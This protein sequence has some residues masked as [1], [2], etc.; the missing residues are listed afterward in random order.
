LEDL[1]HV[2]G[3]LDGCAK[4]ERSHLTRTGD[5]SVNLSQ[6]QLSSNV[7]ARVQPSQ[8]PCAVTAGLPANLGQVSCV[9][10]AE[11]LKWRQQLA[12]KGVPEPHVKRSAT[13]RP[14]SEVQSI[15]ALRCRCEGEE[16][17]RAESTQ[18]TAICRG[19]CVMEF[20]NDHDIESVWIDLIGT[21]AMKRLNRGEDMP[22]NFRPSTADIHLAERSFSKHFTEGSPGLVEKLLTMRDEQQARITAQV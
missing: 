16:H 19:L 2:L 8:V 17:S 3:V 22:A 14:L 6:D 11:I 5:N 9:S 10:N 4:A 21:V 18:E 1:R 7:V 15:A 20:V 12:I 13:V